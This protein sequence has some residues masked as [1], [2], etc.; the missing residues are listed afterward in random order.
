MWER[1]IALWSVPSLWSMT[2]NWSPE[3]GR[4]MLPGQRSDCLQNSAGVLPWGGG[5]WKESFRK[6]ILLFRPDLWPAKLSQKE[7]TAANLPSEAPSKGMPG[8]CSSLQSNVSLHPHSSLLSP[9]NT[10]YYLCACVCVFFS[11][12]FA[13]YWG[14]SLFPFKKCLGYLLSTRRM[15]DLFV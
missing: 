7:Y 11:D 2:W 12:L 10:H 1:Q 4:E 13:P 15:G 9:R 8:I 5:K 14:F 6:K 3:A